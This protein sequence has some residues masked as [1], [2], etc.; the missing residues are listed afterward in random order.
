[1]LPTTQVN[2]STCELPPED[3]A[4]GWQV[5]PTFNDNQSSEPSGPFNLATAQQVAIAMA[6]RTNCL[7]VQ[8]EEVSS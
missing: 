1:M 3:V 6:A 8:I 7:R 2:V 4:F 5:R